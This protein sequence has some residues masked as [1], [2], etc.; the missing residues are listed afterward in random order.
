MLAL[1]TVLA[2]G[3]ATAGKDEDAIKERLAK[4][5]R[6]LAGSGLV[7]LAKQV[8]ALQQ[9]VR[10][11]HGE[12]E[13]QT[14]T[15]EQVRKAQRDAYV[16]TDRRLVAL[17]QGHAAGT[18]AE[19]PLTTTDSP[20]N[21]MVA[22]KPSDQSIAVDLETQ[23]NGPHLDPPPA[24][25]PSVVLPANA[26][27]SNPGLPPAVV[28]AVQQSAAARTG[29][30]SNSPDAEAAY[31]D[32]F[33]LLKAG[34]YEQSIAAFNSYLQ[35]YPASPYADNAQ[36]WLGEAYYVLRQY[37]PAIAEYQKLVAGYPDSLKQS[38]AMLK[39][40]Y[41][42]DKLGQQEQA[43]SELLQLKQKFPGSAAARLAEEQLQRMRVKSP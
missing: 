28:P 26:A 36:Y 13:N 27:L 18:P 15:L 12:L 43:A 8:E 4:V 38:Q 31:R 25:G 11:L 21:V 10:Q 14:F 6:A 32:A 9:E 41:S 39:I 35:Q 34:Q 17:E 24:A 23:P 20:A 22:G 37:P 30:R 2:P 16:D 3:A 1:V 42:Y 19:P 7:E 29:P 5:E 40:G 33:A